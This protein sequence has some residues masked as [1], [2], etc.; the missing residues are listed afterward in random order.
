MKKNTKYIIILLGLLFLLTAIFFILFKFNKI[1][2]RINT[3]INSKEINQKIINERQNYINI[4]YNNIQILKNIDNNNKILSIINSTNK[5]IYLKSFP[6]FYTKD[7]IKNKININN[8]NLSEENVLKI[9]QFIKNNSYHSYPLFKSDELHYPTYFFSIYGSGFCDDV[10]KNFDYLA[11]LYGFKSRVWH[12]QG[13]VVADVYYN[14]KWHIIDPDL[15]GIIRYNNDIASREEMILLAKQN[16]LKN[17]NDVYQKSKNHESTDNYYYKKEK[18]KDPYIKLYPN[19]NIIFLN[20]AYMISSQGKY[21]NE[22]NKE[23]FYKNNRGIGNIIHL[24]PIKTIKKYKIKKIES[25]FPIC[26]IFLKCNNKNK[27]LIKIDTAEKI[28]PQYI[29]GNLLNINNEIYYDYSIACKNMEEYPTR[30]IKLKNQNKI[31]ENAILIIV[32]YYSK[33]NLLINEPEWKEILNSNDLTY[34]MY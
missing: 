33:N 9:Y 29:E 4:Y 13:H 25:Y 12:L 28:I 26:G 7:N 30:Q 1:K 23:E 16:K 32:A 17:Y 5:K 15:L 3:I 20:K 8:N 31:D 22:L 21:I 19:S 24:I 11:N 18:L 27:L 14:D 34:K 10:A 6:L 2:N